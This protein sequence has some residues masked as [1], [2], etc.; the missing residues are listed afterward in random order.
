MIIEVDNVE[1]FLMHHGVKGQ[2]W[3]VRRAQK[4]NAN[5]ALKGKAPLKPSQF[6]GNKATRGAAYVLSYM[7]G[8]SIGA[9][10][11]A[12]P[13]TVTSAIGSTVGSVAGVVVAHKVL[14]NVGSLRVANL[15]NQP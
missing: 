14:K 5:R 13:G 3:G 2:K 15:T 12:G 11:G 9:A 10:I 4:I 1:A 8:G 6:V 7:A